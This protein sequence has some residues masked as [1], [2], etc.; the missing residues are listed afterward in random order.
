MSFMVLCLMFAG[1]LRQTRYS[2][3]AYATYGTTGFEDEGTSCGGQFLQERDREKPELDDGVGEFEDEFED[4]YESEDEILEAGVDGRP[5]AE[6]EAE[7]AEA[8]EVDQQT[9][10]VGRNK[11]EP[12][13]TLSPDLTTYEML[14]ALSTPWPCLSFDILKD[15]LGDNRKTY[16][17]TMYAVWQEPGRKQTRKGK[18]IDGYEV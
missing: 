16:P 6:R 1:S 8:M 13:Q 17:A 18:S 12:G 15:G 10:I 4:E 14:H 9:F 7:E 3:V 5:D 2:P 11:L